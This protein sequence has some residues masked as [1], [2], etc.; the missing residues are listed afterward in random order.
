MQEIQH[1]VAHPG[2]KKV[3]DAYERTLH[4]S[5]EK[6]NHSRNVLSSFGNMSS[7]TVLYVLERFM[8][9]DAQKGDY[10][11]MTALGP[12]FSGELVLLKWGQ[13]A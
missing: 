1:F 5:S 4:L 2:G 7:P 10:G 9:D 8:M 11:L 12:G 13:P 3:L 6:T